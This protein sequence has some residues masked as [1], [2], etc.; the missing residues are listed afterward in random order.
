MVQHENPYLSSVGSGTVVADGLSILNADFSSTSFRV[1]EVSSGATTPRQPIAY[2]AQGRTGDNCLLGTKVLVPIEG[3]VR[4]GVGPAGFA[5]LRDPAKRR[6]RQRPRRARSRRAPPPAGRQ[7]P[8]QRRHDRAASAEPVDPPVGLAPAGAGSVEL[9]RCRCPVAGWFCHS[10]GLFVHRGLL[11]AVQQASWVPA[12]LPRR[13]ARSTTPL[14]AARAVLEVDG[15]SRT[16]TVQRTPFKTALWRLLGV[17]IGS[18]VFD[19]GCFADR[20]GLADLRRRLHTQRRQHGPIPFPG[21]RHLQVRPQRHRC[22]FT[23]G[24]GSFVHYGVT[25]GAGAAVAPDSF[26]MKGGG[27]P[28][29]RWGGNPAIEFST[30]TTATSARPPP[31]PPPP[32]PPNPPPPLSSPVHVLRRKRTPQ[33]P[34]RPPAGRRAPAKRPGPRPPPPPPPPGATTTPRATTT[35]TSPTAASSASTGAQATRS[36]TT[37]AVMTTERRRPSDDD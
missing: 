2:P 22:G 10:P 25:I 28:L 17:R 1:S 15:G 13:V 8:A 4:E 11:R 20:A 30:P 27:P 19:D 21:G 37:S 31:P 34:T 6:A 16:S 9:Y 33:R 14:L 12:A 18:R 35:S 26:V 3:E 23:L 5:Q 36:S 32:P 29:D 7:E 24:V